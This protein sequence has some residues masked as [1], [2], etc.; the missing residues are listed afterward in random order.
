[1]A[2]ALRNARPATSPRIGGWTS[3]SS[4]PISR[5]SKNESSR[6]ASSRSPAAYSPYQPPTG[7]NASSCNRSASQTRRL[8]GGGRLT[9]QPRRSRLGLGGVAIATGEAVQRPIGRIVPTARS[10]TC[11]FRRTSGSASRTLT[12]EPLR[13]LGLFFPLGLLQLG[14]RI[15]R[16][17]LQLVIPFGPPPSAEIPEAL[18]EARHPDSLHSPRETVRLRLR[19]GKSRLRR[20]AI[21]GHALPAVAR[22]IR[23]GPGQPKARSPQPATARRSHLSSKPGPGGSRPSCSSGPRWRTV[24]LREQRE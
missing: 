12:G 9:F 24:A 2:Q 13:E 1:L 15:G 4:S 14:S 7:R 10:L 5:P 16:K 23:R 3:R 17:A 19:R 8:A 11:R 22:A 21:R 18:F 20:H 6:A